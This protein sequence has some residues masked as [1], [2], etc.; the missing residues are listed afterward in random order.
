MGRRSARCP[1]AAR[2]CSSRSSRRMAG[3]RAGSRCR[4]IRRTTA[5]PNGCFARP[6][7]SR[8]SPRTSSSSSRRRRRDSPAIEAATERGINVN[9]TVCFSVA[10]AVAA[11]EAIERGLAR[12]ESA[13]EPIDRMGPVVTLMMGRV[14]DWLHTLV[15]R[16]GV[17]VDPVAVPWAGVAIFKRAYGLFRERGYRSRLLGAAM[18]HHYHWSQLIGGDVVITMPPAWQ[19]R[20]NA[21]LG[22]GPARHRR[23]SRPGDRRGTAGALPR[24]PPR[25][26]ARRHDRGRVRHVRPDR[27]G[28]PSVHL[29]VPRPAAPGPRRGAAGS[30]HPEELDRSRRASATVHPSALPNDATADQLRLRPGAD[31]TVA[32]DPARAGWRYL[33]FRVERLEA[34]SEI[35]VGRRGARGGRCQPCRRG[36]RD[37]GR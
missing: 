29:L 1:S 31:G 36:G 30:R 10:Q 35:R 26:R 18:R 3:G 28:P 2:V 8:R 23:S 37:L 20:F 16:D 9:V 32:V 11:A 17:I 24:L 5:P 6:P 25:L 22:A 15:E 13:G 19:R 34:G 7:G 33:S 14:E 21:L 12:R 27:P 4:P